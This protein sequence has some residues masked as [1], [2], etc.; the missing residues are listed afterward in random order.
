[1]HAKLVRSYILDVLLQPGNR[2][3]PPTP[4]AGATFLGRIG[5]GGFRSHPGVG[6]GESL[7]T[8][9][10]GPI[11][12]ALLC[13]AHLIHA[14]FFGEGAGGH[15]PAVPGGMQSLP[16]RSRHAGEGGPIAE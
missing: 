1:M 9:G 14:A 10:K 8:R 15:E 11:G 13:G 7:R 6:L 12:G 16:S 4:E 5:E 3:E 2:T